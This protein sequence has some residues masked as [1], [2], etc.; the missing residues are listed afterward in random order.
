MKTFI[1]NLER[2]VARR[3]HILGEVTKHNLDFEF[4]KA[5]DGAALSDDEFN[6][7]MDSEAMK[8]EPGILTRGTLGCLL[9]HLDVFRRIVEEDLDMAF[10]L[11][12]DAVLPEDIDEILYDVA[13]NIAHS[14]IVL[15]Y[16]YSFSPCELS[17]NGAVEIGGKRKLMFPAKIDQPVSSAAYVITR[18]VANRLLRLELPM[19]TACDDWGH[20]Y[21]QGGFDSLRCIYPSPVS[22]SGAKSTIQTFVQSGLRVKITQFIEDHKIPLFSDLL[23]RA[24]LK[25]LETKSAV[26]FVSKPS[27][28][29]AKAAGSQSV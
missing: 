29:A 11:E 12:D 27:P 7:L 9:S 19:K 25:D 18:E 3:E 13:A 21:Q 2:S 1:I 15:L 8:Q 14:E 16:F 5:V 23:R 4:I 20:W 6:R 28:I 24:R 26:K 22:I 10:V 17:E